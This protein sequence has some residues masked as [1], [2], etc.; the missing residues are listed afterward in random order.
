MQ[1]KGILKFQASDND[2]D[3]SED[4]IVDVDK[5]TDSNCNR[6]EGVYTLTVL[7]TVFVFLQL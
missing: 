7:Y 1:V 5:E 2:S 3:H 6:T 4:T